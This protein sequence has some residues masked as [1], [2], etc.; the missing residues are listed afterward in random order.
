MTSVMEVILL[1]LMV[2]DEFSSFP[3]YRMTMWAFTGSR[4]RLDYF[5]LKEPMQ[6][7]GLPGTH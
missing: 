4:I 5:V 6:R 1:Y 3:T 7:L 2:K